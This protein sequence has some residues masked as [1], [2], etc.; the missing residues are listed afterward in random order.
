M[1]RLSLAVALVGAVAAAGCGG[2]KAPSSAGT[3]KGTPGS[4]YTVEVRGDLY[5]SPD[6]G[7]TTV[8]RPQYGVITSDDGQ[9][10]CGGANTACT[11]TFAWSQTVTLTAT[12]IG[13]YFFEGWAGDCGGGANTC[14]LSAGA[15]KLVL[16]RFSGSR[17]GHP[18]WSS[19][20][21]H[22]SAYMAFVTNAQGHLDCNTCHGGDLHG[23]SI[24]PSCFSCHTDP[25][26]TASDPVVA[27]NWNPYPSGFLS[28]HFDPSAAAWGTHAPGGWTGGA[29][30]CLRCHTAQGFQD[31]VGVDGSA[32]YSNTATWG[33][34]TST[35]VAGTGLPGAYA[36]GP[37]TCV[38]CHNSVSDP[39]A[40]S[41]ITTVTFPSLVQVQTD[42]ATAVCAQCHQA[43]ESTVSVNTAIG[44][45]GFDAIINGTATGL[46]FK[47]P[48]Y[49]GAAATMYGSV[50]QG[51]A[52]YPGK[53][54][55]GQNLHG[56]NAGTCVSCHDP[57]TLDVTVNASTCGRCHFDETTGAPVTSFA[58]LEENRQFGFREVDVDGNG[59]VES[60]SLEI[61]GLKATLL[62]A[63]QTYSQNVVGYGVC[64]SD[65]NYP[66]FMQHTGGPG[67]CTSTET[68]AFKKFTPRSLRAAYNLKFASTDF[69][70]WAHNPRYAIEVLYDAITDLN[71]GLAAAG[72]A[73]VPFNGVRAFTGHFGGYEPA[74]A[75]TA[76]GEA[77]TDWNSPSGQIQNSCTPCHGGAQGQT[78]YQASKP[79]APTATV[80]SITAFQC[81]T[82]H[83]P[84]PTD[85]DFKSMRAAGTIYLPLGKSSAAQRTAFDPTLDTTAAA[86]IKPGDLMCMTCHTG[87]EGNLSGGATWAPGGVTV[88][89]W[90]L[91]FKN[92]H[93]LGA[94]GLV[95]GGDAQM[96]A[97]YAGQTYVS[98]TAFWNKPH[99]SPHGQSCTACHVPQ[100]SGHSFEV[101]RD[102]TIPTGTFY[103]AVNTK[104][105][106]GC[107]TGA[108][109]LD[110]RKTNLDNLEALLYATVQT[111]AQGNQASGG[112]DTV[113]YDG[114]RYPYWFVQS[115]AVCGT[116]TA[117]FN[118]NALKAAF[119]YK[120]YQAE[121][122]AYIHNY[123]YMAEGLIDSI[124]DLNPAAV[125]PV[126]ANP[127][128]APGTVL[129]RP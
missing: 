60:L 102:T 75:G 5:W 17:H 27:G 71:A 34:T 16:V 118:G 11:A 85:T 6:G 110:W 12:P 125:L 22:A 103:G 98:K 107:H 80:A 81:T 14:S 66:Y 48:H 1:R 104:T 101:D 74:F 58:Q 116:T 20:T 37:M 119:N 87:R 10:N 79:A 111:Y 18:N 31:Y 28:G 65:A 72:Q 50:A 95:M 70:A 46:S 78:N 108:Y 64:F 113:C 52:Q 106:N 62:T 8:S 55:T 56:V 68:S 47:N 73:T 3:N 19:P 36:T 59:K 105:C 93:Y 44:S 23:L 123:E 7:I 90:T 122:G 84:Q 32:E 57:H 76:G 88:T 99:G 112:T 40:T 25:L 49:R 15:D 24:A 67:P 121:P 126:D 109:T 114:A 97:Q 39:T 129:V 61:E 54:Y 115:G 86:I 21:Q 42:K 63:L 53:I 38:E 51:W 26:P 77:F 127:N 30:G 69:A 29:G 128:V 117:T 9:I 89:T 4:T 124:M 100:A 35:T 94:F 43:R 96:L 120:W 2:S 83:A 91:G 13:A 41:G 82:C 33:A 92:P 45:T